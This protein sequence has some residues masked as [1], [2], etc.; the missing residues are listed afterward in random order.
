MPMEQRA[1]AQRAMGAAQHCLDAC[2]K[3]G[4]YG[5]NLKFAVH[6]T[7]VCAAFAGSFLL[8]LAKLFPEDLQLESILKRVEILADLLSKSECY[9]FN[10]LFKLTSSAP[11][12]RYGRS[13]KLMLNRSMRQATPSELGKASKLPP[14]MRV[15]MSATGGSTT[16]ETTTNNNAPMTTG[17]IQNPAE[18][19]ISDNVNWGIL[20]VKQEQPWSPAFLNGIGIDTST[21]TPTSQSTF[22]SDGIM[23]PGFSLPMSSSGELPLWLQETN[24]GDL[25]VTNTGTEAFFL[26]SEDFSNFA[27][28]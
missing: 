4:E 27:L 13:L 28:I 9:V 2:I 15:P 22:T 3:P 14:V 8:R 25:G 18:T 1:I 11:A 7:H 19:T 21:S 20:D 5:N 16:G 12:S 26:P 10:V 6:Y 17:I 24:L 23:G